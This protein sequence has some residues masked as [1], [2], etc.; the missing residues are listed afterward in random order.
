MQ[1]GH[2]IIFKDVLFFEMEVNLC[3]NESVS[4]RNW[5]GTCWK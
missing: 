1:D 3:Q 4:K 5:S 2:D